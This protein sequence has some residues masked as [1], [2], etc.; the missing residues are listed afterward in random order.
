MLSDVV[1]SIESDRIQFILYD[2]S[3]M[4]NNKIE[5]VLTEVEIFIKWM[6]TF[7]TTD[8]RKYQLSMRK[9]ATNNG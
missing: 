8:N 5:L 2:Q 7:L 9:I 4:L 3:I 1:P 6:M